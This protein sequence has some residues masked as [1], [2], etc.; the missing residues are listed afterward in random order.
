MAQFLQT[1]HWF[2]T[3]KTFAK[4]LEK[5]NRAKLGRR[6]KRSKRRQRSM[7]AACDYSCSTL[8]WH[9]HLLKL[10]FLMPSP[11]SVTDSKQSQSAFAKL[12][13]TAITASLYLPVRLL[14][15]TDFHKI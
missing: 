7:I 6:K 12:R 11:I 1:L 13:K 15:R 3:L 14:A 10:R 4:T 5:K 8:H 9:W 2:R